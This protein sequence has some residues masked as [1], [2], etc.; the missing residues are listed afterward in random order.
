MTVYLQYST[1][2]GT[3]WR[4]TTYRKYDSISK[5]V[6]RDFSKLIKRND[7]QAA[8]INVFLPPD[9]CTSHGWWRRST[10]VV[11]FIDDDLEAIWKE[12]GY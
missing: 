1:T 8:I 11:E 12:G 5:K 2:N 6:L 7:V 10:G 4:M 9:D 3:F